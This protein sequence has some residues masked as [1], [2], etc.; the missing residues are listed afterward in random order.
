MRG[1]DTEARAAQ[2]IRDALAMRES[3]DA[4]GALRLLQR[5]LSQLPHHAQAH[6]LVGLWCAQDGDNETARPHLERAVSLMPD[7]GDAYLALGNV[8]RATGD[9]RR[10]ERCYGDAVARA[11]DSAAGHYNLGLL[12]K[13]NGALEPALSCFERACALS[14][15]IEDA[16]RERISCLLQLSRHEEAK[17]VARAALDE[18]RDSAVLWNCLGLVHQKLFQPEEAL[19]CYGRSTSLAKPDHEIYNNIGIALQ[20]AGRISEAIEAYDKSIALKPDYELARFHRALAHLLTHDYEQ[21]WENYELRLMSE[22]RPFPPQRFPRWR[23]ESL[24]GRSI[25]VHGEQGLGDEI[26]FASCLP[27]V[28]QQ[29]E[30]C[31]VWCSPKLELLFQR[32]FPAARVQPFC[33][34]RPDA[35]AVEDAVDFEVPM[36]SLPLY[37]RRTKANFPVHAGYLRAD[38]RRVAYWRER[39]AVLGE[40]PKIG[41]SWSGGTPKTR[42]AVRSLSLSEWQPI[43]SQNACFVSLQYGPARADVRALE[44]GGKAKI[45]EWMEA[46]DD[47]DETAALVSALD[48]TISVCTAVIHLAGALGRP[49]WIMAPM[50]PEWR[51]GIAGSEMPWYPSARVF[52]Q[53]VAGQ[54][55]SVV[56]EVASELHRLASPCAVAV[57]NTQQE[58]PNRHERRLAD[59]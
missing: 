37:L 35:M 5:I 21:A 45:V 23:G 26:M 15:Y 18:H 40:G 28:L 48:L 24:A 36:G 42:R 14:P 47:Y 25:L 19:R 8:C 34:D 33:F 32:S 13:A 6:Y 9:L 50:S 57:A 55:G 27:Q 53:T 52:R 41:V 3:G 54:W 29:A 22:D 11:P 56:E 20:D 43:L 12:L 7:S 17:A 51:Y 44:A 30:R 2:R 16:R 49:V 59:L 38:A 1:S 46:L 10:A 31:T 39:L 58:T 4:T